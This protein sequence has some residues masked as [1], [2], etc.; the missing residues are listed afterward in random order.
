MRSP[1]DGPVG[2]QGALV[3]LLA[4]EER[5]DELVADARHQAEVMLACAEEEAG[6][7]L[8]TVRGDL[9]AARRELKERV[10]QERSDAL[11]EIARRKSLQLEA[12]AGIG[13]DEIETLAELVVERV[14]AGAGGGS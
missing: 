7:R 11:A 12:V 4:A 6:E 5:L 13:P 8:A 1:I 2:E 9:E 3:R 10:N 14:L